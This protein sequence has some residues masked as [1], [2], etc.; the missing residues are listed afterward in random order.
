MSVVGID[1]LLVSLRSLHSLHCC[2]AFRRDGGYI[3]LG[4][5]LFFWGG[6][7]LLLLRRRLRLRFLDLV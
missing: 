3:T 6:G 4:V 7:F 5:R 2:V 1:T